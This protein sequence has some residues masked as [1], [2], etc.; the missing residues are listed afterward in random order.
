MVDEYGQLQKARQLIDSDS[1][2]RRALELLRRQ[3]GATGWGI[4]KTLGMDPE[5]VREALENLRTTGLI[6][7]DAEGGS[8]LE[9]FYFLTKLAYMMASAV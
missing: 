2:S 8:G 6:D 7:A 3:Q 5:R 4:A 9:G 1:V